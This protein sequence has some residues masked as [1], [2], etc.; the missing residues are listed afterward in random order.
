MCFLLLISCSTER[1]KRMHKSAVC[2]LMLMLLPAAMIFAGGSQEESTPE[3]SDRLAQVEPDWYVTWEF[4]D[5]EIIFTMAAPTTGWVSIGFN[6]SQRMRDAAFVIG[7]I[8]NNGDVQIRED[9]GTGNTSHAS[10][11]SL[12]GTEDVRVLSGTTEEGKTV[13][14]FALPLDSGDSYDVVF[15]P[16]ETYTM[17]LA[18]GP[19]GAQNFT[20]R[21]RSRTSLEVQLNP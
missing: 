1:E 17:L 5:D 8:D 21:H 2:L 10:D 4:I 20:A 6:P 19:E 12:G 9:Y 16:G 15:T 3:V 18:Y 7:Y 13:I 14:T 11:I